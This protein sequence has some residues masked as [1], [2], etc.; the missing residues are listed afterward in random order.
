MPDHKNSTND[1]RKDERVDASVSI[2]GEKKVGV[3]GSS[4]STSVE[5]NADIHK[6]KKP[7]CS[8]S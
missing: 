2:K 8:I 1:E 5:L 7:K 3:A 4:F 6:P